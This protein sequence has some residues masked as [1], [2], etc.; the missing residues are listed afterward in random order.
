MAMHCT[1]PSN[2]AIIAVISI[3]VFIS[4]STL[5]VFVSTNTPTY[6]N[7]SSG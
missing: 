3:L 6:Y 1:E 4:I 5:V 7:L 2:S